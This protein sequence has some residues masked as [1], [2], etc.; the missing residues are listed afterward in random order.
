[1]HWV[2]PG[3]R[4]AVGS[5]GLLRAAGRV[6]LVA[7]FPM[8]IARLLAVIAAVLVALLAARPAQAADADAGSLPVPSGTTEPATPSVDA[9]GTPATAA[10][11]TE[12]TVTLPP[13]ATAQAEGLPIATI[14]ISGARRVT[15][16]DVLSYMRE[17]PGH[18]FKADV[19]TTDVRALWD[20]GF[21]DDIQVDLVHERSGRQAS[22]SRPRAAQRSR[23]RPLRRQHRD[24]ERQAH[25]G[26]R[27]QTEHDSQRAVGQPQRAEI[28]DAYA[29]KGFF[30]ADVSY[31]I[32]RGRDNEV[33]LKFKV[34]EHQPVTVRRVTFVGN[35]HVP[36]KELRDQMQTG[37]GGFFCVRFRRCVP[38]GRLRARRADAERPLL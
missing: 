34:V 5:V 30:L 22:R 14:D 16:E 26:R 4:G 13:T 17:K 18:I 19:L 15:R 7:H 3:G 28:K 36:D 9:G 8:R 6:S 11:Q 37:N 24:R 12:P 38:A 23:G 21:F 20:S 27:G 29:E 25:R 2:D 10:A 31:D 35:E 32:V 33:V 1:M